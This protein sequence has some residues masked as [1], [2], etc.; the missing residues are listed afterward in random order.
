ME[1]K[2]ASELVKSDDRM[3][4][5]EY[6]AKWIMHNIEKANNAGRD[7]TCFTPTVTRVNGRYIDCEPELRKAFRDAGY[8]FEPTGYI[9]GVWQRTIDICW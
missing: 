9:G 4:A 6:C 8:K 7:R 3:Q 1:I 5:M 2:K